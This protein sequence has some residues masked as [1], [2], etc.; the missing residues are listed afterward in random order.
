MAGISEFLFGSGDKLKKVSNYSPEQQQAFKSLMAQ[1]GGGG[2]LN[3]GYGNALGILQ[4]YLDPQSDIYRNFE[5]PYLQEF[6]EQIIPQL[7]E[8]YAGLG[9]SGMSGALSSSGFGQS[10]G[11]AGS[12]LQT[13]LAQMKSTMQNQALQRILGQYNQSLQTGLGAEPFSYQQQQGSSGFLGPILGAAGTAFA[14]PFGGALGK[15][16]GSGL[17]NL[18]KPKQDDSLF[19]TYADLFKSGAISL[20]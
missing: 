17:S 10:L 4:Q 16:A 14:G 1:L 13:N 3:Q 11:A 5:Q 6:N 19:N 8:R 2:A 18:F 7:A 12:Q 9:G 15:M 20:T